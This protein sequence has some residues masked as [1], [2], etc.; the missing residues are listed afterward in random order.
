M[1]VDS[2][3]GDRLAAV[4]ADTVGDDA[5]W[6]LAE[7]DAGYRIVLADRTLALERRVDPEGSTHWITTLRADGETVGKFGPDES[8]AA[9]LDR[10][11]T[12]LSSDA[13]YTVCCDG[14][15]E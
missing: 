11:R 9:L 14:R 3:L 5:D 8:T 7:T 10:C 15:P 2:S 4:A 6:T 12:I 13:T 1:T